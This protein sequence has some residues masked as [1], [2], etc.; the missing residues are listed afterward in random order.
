MR[1]LL[2]L[3]VFSVSVSLLYFVSWLNLLID[4][5]FLKRSQIY[6]RRNS[7]GDTDPDGKVWAAP[8]RW[9]TMVIAYKKSKFKELNLDPVEVSS[10]SSVTYHCLLVKVL[11]CRH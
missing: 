4:F 3:V 10:S 6:L 5:L 8:Y 11:P 9:G 1:T 2:S 7:N